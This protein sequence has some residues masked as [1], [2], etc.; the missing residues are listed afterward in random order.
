MT[1]DD[2]AALSAALDGVEL[3]LNAA[4]P[5]VRT[6]APLAEACLAAGAHYIDIGNELQVFL[7][8]YDLDQRAQRAG[9]TIMPGVGFGVVATN[10]LARYV[11]DAVGGAQQLEVAARA[12][13]ARQGPG[14]TA[15]VR[16]NLPYGGWTRQACRQHPCP[17]GSGIN[18]HPRPTGAD[19]RHALPL[20][21]TWKRLSKPPG[22]LTSPRTP[23]YQPIPPP[24]I[25]RPQI[26]EAAGPPDLPVIR[27]GARHRT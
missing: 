20:P 13:A 12:A 3:G 11:S 8:L 5:F 6:A 14:I 4:G 27:L 21:V 7:A 24:S 18:N 25:P 15:S 26:R 2:P 17:L 16:E 10:C 9:V 22:P 19:A 1:L 23:P